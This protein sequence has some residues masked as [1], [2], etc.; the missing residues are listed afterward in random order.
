[1]LCTLLLS[2]GASSAFAQD[3]SPPNTKR[4]PVLSTQINADF[5]IRSCDRLVIARIGSV[6][7]FDRKPGTLGSLGTP[8]TRIAELDIVSAPFGSKTERVLV[9]IPEGTTPPELGAWPLG[10]NLL[11]GSDDWDGFA[12]LKLRLH[13]DPLWMPWP[14]LEGPWPVRDSANG[15]EVCVPDRMFGQAQDSTFAVIK[16]SPRWVAVREL[17]SVLTAELSRITPRIEAEISTTGTGRWVVEVDGSGGGRLDSGTI[18]EPHEPQRFQWSDAQRAAWKEKLATCKFAAMPNQ[19]GNSEYPCSSVL[20]LSWVTREGRHTSQYY[21][22]ASR[23][24]VD[25]D[26]GPRFLD[27]WGALRAQVPKEAK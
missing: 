19:V 4:A 18:F 16:P 21:G 9:R 7:E 27:L 5:L 2:L 1:M 13:A 17:E 6:R 3:P 12:R 24:G 23:D 22:P 11:E 20:S 14:E 25:A 26:W 8:K 10:H 15:Q